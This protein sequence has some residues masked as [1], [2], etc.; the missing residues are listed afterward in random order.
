MPCSEKLTM[1]GTKP[2]VQVI[3][4]SVSFMGIV[5]INFLR[6]IPPTMLVAGLT[7]WIGV[8]LEMARV[9]C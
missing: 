9:F 3:I 7:C 1:G 8:P 6:K 5:E 4:S 2:S